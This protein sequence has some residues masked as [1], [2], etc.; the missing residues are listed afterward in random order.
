MQPASIGAILLSVLAWH[1]P[2]RAQ[3]SDADLTRRLE[4]QRSALH[5]IELDLVTAQADAETIRATERDVAARLVDA[6][7]RIGMTEYAIAHLAQAESLL[8]CDIAE[9]RVRDETLRTKVAERQSIMARRVRVLYVQGRR[10][11]YERAL[12]ASSLTHWL[13]AR[14]Y[15]ATLNRRDLIDVQHLRAD[16]SRLN[17]LVV[18]QREQRDMLDSL[19]VRR[20]EQRGHL[21]VA[22][23]EARDLLQRVRRSRRLIERATA[24]LEAQRR[25]SESKITEYLA[26][27]E[28]AGALAARGALVGGA[29]ALAPVDFG[30][31][32][33]HLPWPV[34][35]RIVSTFGRSHDELTRT[36]TRNRGI[37]ISASK[38]TD[39]LAVASGHVVMVDWFRG[40]GS[41]VIL[42]HG[43]DYYT[44][45]AHLDAVTVR[46][47]DRVRRGQAVGISG[48]SG[49]LGEAKVHFEL[50]AGREALNP[51]DWLTPRGRDSS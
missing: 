11:P 24:E 19:I 7:N 8:T 35:G 6:S 46:R 42:F 17:A 3:G 51:L 40:Y 14:Q 45:Y 13:A 37:D 2:S 41:F 28:Q 23:R 20:R 44:V 33:G 26:A 5:Q 34:E 47:N 15:L 31:E 48:D 9:A 4:A 27:Q 39:V 49:T 25:E 22:E 1:S 10:H 18:L 38:G 36:W 21:L 12:L 29:S 32:K 50:L 43:Q 30:E 16:R